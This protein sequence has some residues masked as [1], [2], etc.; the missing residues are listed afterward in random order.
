V[1][2]KLGNLGHCGVAVVIVFA[3]LFLLSIPHQFTNQYGRWVKQFN[4]YGIIPGWTFFAPN[5]GTSDYLFVYRDV[6]PTGF[7]EWREIEWCRRRR[8]LDAV[9][10]PDRHRTKLIVDCISCLLVTVQ[11]MRKL[12]IDVEG[13]PQAWIVSVPYMALLNIAVLM[14]RIS[15]DATARQFAIIDQ[16]PSEPLEKPRLLVCSFPHDLK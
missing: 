11:E 6:V 16:K 1:L 4:K 14:P 3:I 9:W 12:G 5:P 8:L 13:R 7:G 10:H 15:L 2:V